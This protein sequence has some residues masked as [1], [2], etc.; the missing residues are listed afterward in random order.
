MDFVKSNSIDQ[1]KKRGT[2]VFNWSEVNFYQSTSYKIY[3]LG[4]TSKFKIRYAVNTDEIRRRE[5]K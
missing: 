2:K 4:G 1:E 3:T 5:A